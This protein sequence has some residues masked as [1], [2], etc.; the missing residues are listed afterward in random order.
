[1]QKLKDNKIAYLKSLKHELFFNFPVTLFLEAYF[2]W[3]I[4]GYLQMQNWAYTTNGEIIGIAISIF[5]LVVT[6]IIFPLLFIRF[7]RFPVR[8]YAKESF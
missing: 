1:M 7:I 8:Y 2:E 4:S 5:G 3:L 6:L